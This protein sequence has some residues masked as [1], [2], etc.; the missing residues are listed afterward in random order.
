MG[1]PVT[2]G[3]EPDAVLNA[4]TGSFVLAGSPGH[5]LRFGEFGHQGAMFRDAPVP[6][7]CELRWRPRVAAGAR[8]GFVHL[9]I[10]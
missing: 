9:A 1:M 5:P 7:L 10:P 8:L 2:G 4:E 3:A 6:V